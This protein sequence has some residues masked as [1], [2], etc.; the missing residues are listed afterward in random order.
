M[1]IEPSYFQQRSATDEQLFPVQALSEYSLEYA[2]ALLLN[3]C[4]R[5]A[6]K[7]KCELEVELTLQV[8]LA[9]LHHSDIQVRTFINGIM[10][11]LLDLSLLKQRARALNLKAKLELLLEDSQEDELKRQLQYILNKLEE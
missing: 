4:L 2:S 5:R 1:A 6:G 9:L 3:L 7:A 11:S 8:T 10:Y